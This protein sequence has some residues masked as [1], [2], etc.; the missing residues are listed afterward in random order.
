[1]VK[2]ERA[3]P[4]FNDWAGV[5]DLLRDAFAYME[6]RVDPPSSLNRLDL[7]G[8]VQKVREETVILAFDDE[9]LI[10]CA[11]LRDMPDALYV[12]KVAVSPALRNSGV[13]RKMITQAERIAKDKGHQYLELQTRIELVENHRAFAAMGFIK[14]NEYAHEGYSRPT[15]ITMRKAINADDT[16]RKDLS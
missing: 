14:F 11:F 3:S 5:L 13:A 10:G 8:I 1:M 16:A 2:V 15:S 7:A 9:A 12:G 6:G 4:D